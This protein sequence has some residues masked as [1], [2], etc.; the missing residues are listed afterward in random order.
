MAMGTREQVSTIG[1]EGKETKPIYRGTIHYS[2]TDRGKRVYG[3]FKRVSVVGDDDDMSVKAN[4]TLKKEFERRFGKKP[5]ARIERIERH[6]KVDQS[7]HK[8]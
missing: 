3:S 7:F 2:Y 6:E 8:Y 5:N 1:W 4:H